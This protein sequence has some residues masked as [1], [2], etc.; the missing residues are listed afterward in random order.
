[1]KKTV[2]AWAGIVNNKLHRKSDEQFGYMAVFK[3]KRE[4]KNNYELYVPCTITY[5]STPN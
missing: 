3:S 1:M 4:A 5:E 2:K